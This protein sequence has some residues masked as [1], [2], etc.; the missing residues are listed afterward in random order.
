MSDCCTRPRTDSAVSSHTISSLTSS[1]AAVHCKAM[2]ALESLMSEDAHNSNAITATSPANPQSQPPQSSYEI[3]LRSMYDMNLEAARLRSAGPPP[4]PTPPLPS[5]PSSASSSSPALVTPPANHDASNTGTMRLRSHMLQHIGAKRPTST[6]QLPLSFLT[7][8]IRRVFPSDLDN[9][10]WEQSLMALDY[11]RDLEK[12]RQRE[13]H[14]AKEKLCVARDVYGPQFD[15]FSSE[16]ENE[17]AAPV[18]DARPVDSWIDKIEEQSRAAGVLYSKIYLLVRQWVR[19]VHPPDHSTFTAA[20]TSLLPLDHHHRNVI[21]AL[22]PDQL[23][24]SPKHTFPPASANTR[25]NG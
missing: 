9:V 7:T 23:S 14:T 19:A 25:T 1:S 5:S 17:P 8:F 6:P 2:T 12:R 3:P 21:R 11:L 20:N 15:P 16:K 24:S 10:A 18:S 22:Q 13:M 4:P